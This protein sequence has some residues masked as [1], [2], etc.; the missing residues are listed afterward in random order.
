MK[1]A[2]LG[3]SCCKVLMIV[4]FLSA[5]EIQGE[6]IQAIESKV[7]NIGRQLFIFLFYRFTKMKKFSYLVAA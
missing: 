4:F 3:G 5:F 6:I 2:F 1:T 7:W